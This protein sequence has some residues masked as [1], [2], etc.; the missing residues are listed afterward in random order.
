MILW[1]CRVIW[2]FVKYNF[3]VCVWV[4]FVMNCLKVW[5]YEIFF[6]EMLGFFGFV[7]LVVVVVYIILYLFKKL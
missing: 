6:F 2:I 1:V 7:I 3:S 4:Y 5:Y